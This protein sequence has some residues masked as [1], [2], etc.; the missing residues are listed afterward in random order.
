MKTHV[1][2]VLSVCLAALPPA[3][4]LAGVAPAENG[5]QEF[6]GIPYDYAVYRSEDSARLR[7][8]I[9]YQVFNRMLRFEPSKDGFSCDYEATVVID[10]QRGN[11]VDRYSKAR[12][13]T[14]QSLQRAESRLDFRTNEV[15]FNLL[16]GSYDVHISIA[17]NKAQSVL[18][19]DFRVELG[20]LDAKNPQ[21]SDIAFVKEVRPRG[22]EPSG[23]DKGDWVIV[24][25]VG[26][27]FGG[28]DNP[29]LLFY[30]EIYPGRRPTD[31]V[32]VETVL[33]SK[34]KGMVYRDTIET[35]LDKPILRQ[36][37]D[38]SLEGYQPGRYELF[39]DI[40][41]H[42]G[43]RLDRTY[44]EFA[45]RWSAA[46]LLKNDYKRAVDQLAYLASG[47]EIKNLRKLENYDERVAAFNAFWQKR[48]PIP[49]TAENEAR[50]EFYRRID[51]ANKRF[52]YVGLEGWR[53]DRGRIYTQFGEPDQYD[54]YPFVPDGYPYQ[55]WHYYR[56]G[57]YRRFTFVDR[58]LDG[59]YRLIYPYDGLGLTPDF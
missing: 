53:T 22:E 15:N 58:T 46:G 52:T 13:F 16:P 27:E 50:V 51:V 14:V 39:V 24:P 20:N 12:T 37:R 3:P 9:Y 1:A 33:R 29:R 31:K 38:I 21:L 44:K 23:F 47:D 48:D 30:L 8:E 43:K 35:S 42:R 41:G 11:Q 55:E 45:V 40:L 19:R 6:A 7:L 18:R 10:D 34:V 56:D 26:D 17:D 28:D 57:R 5:F 54:D 59:D 4:G 36:V 32:T 2:A 25:A 49:E